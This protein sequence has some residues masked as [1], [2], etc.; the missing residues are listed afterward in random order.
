MPKLRLLAYVMQLSRPRVFVSMRG[1]NLSIVA[2]QTRRR[3]VAGLEGPCSTGENLMKILTALI[4]AA[5]S[6]TVV[7][8]ASARPHHHRRIL[9]II[10]HHPHHRHR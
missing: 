7:S 3:N 8:T 6:L 10:H 5:A 4:I 1:E 2:G 9:P